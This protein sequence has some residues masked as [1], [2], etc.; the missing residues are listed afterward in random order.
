MK[1]ATLKNIM[2]RFRSTTLPS[3]AIAPSR[4]ATPRPVIA[5][6]S[7]STPPP[8]VT[9]S[10]NGNYYEALRESHDRTP[11]P[12]ASANL[13]PQMA[14]LVGS[15]NRRMI[16]ALGRYL[17]DN[18]SDVAYAIK[19]IS[20]YSAP[21]TP[22]SDCPDQESAKAFNDYFR[23]WSKNCDHTRRFNLAELQDIICSAVDA[24]GDI[25]SVMTLES[26][27]PRVRL[28]DTFHIGNQFATDAQD[29]VVTDDANGGVLLGYKTIEGPQD[30]M[31][32][33]ASGYYTADQFLL[34]HDPERYDKYRG[35]SPI[36]R[37]SND[38][39]DKGDI[40][41]FVKLKEKI[42]SALAAVIQQKGMLEEDHWGN[43]TGEGGTNERTAADPNRR[44]VDS[45]IS[46][47]EL[48]GGDIPVVDGELK[49]LESNFNGI[50]AIEFI[51]YLAGQ[52][53][54]GFG[55][56]PAF[57]LD[58]KLTGPNLRSVIG[59][60]QRKFDKRKA[61]LAK[62][63]EWCWLR[64]IAHGIASGE[65]KAAAGWDR[66]TLQFPPLLLIDLGDQMS[67]ERSDVMC[68]QMSERERFGNRG[69]DHCAE[70]NQIVSE[71]ETK[72]QSAMALKE[73]FPD[74]P[75]P[76]ILG[77]LG[78]ATSSSVTET[79]TQTPPTGDSQ[80]DNQADNSKTKN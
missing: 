43:D 45:K 42:S 34:I 15:L 12:Y 1:L 75:L 62:F 71:V 65:L 3:V 41:A 74:V 48:L 46:L 66:I 2:P 60:A 23:T 52:F 10:G 21:V 68:G 6:A 31:R 50:N 59:K 16:A 39:R 17:A 55:L 24:E 26:G 72:L 47:A 38:L 49:Q 44:P 73:K 29:G 7:T 80:A 13:H 32:G 53:V 5:R 78:F 77:R 4:P 22:H 61:V 11:V 20:A 33:V 9:N 79:Q 28:Y 51:E 36:R 40:K 64:V 69:K 57:Y 8:A 37:G 58:E 56:P 30:E 67:N 63:V 76:L 54:A 18:C 27:A 35:I 25:G 19:T 14:R 70:H